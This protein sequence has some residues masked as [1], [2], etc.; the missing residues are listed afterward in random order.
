MVKTSADGRIRNAWFQITQP[1][2]ASYVAGGF[3][4]T[5]P[6]VSLIKNASVFMTPETLLATTKNVGLVL[7][8]TGAVATVKVLQRSDAA[9]WTEVIDGIN[10]SGANF[11][12]T[13][14]GV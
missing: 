12:L 13:G 3:K 9:L 8:T 5:V 14:K 6:G 1:G 7:T 11:I 10:L 4:I 2:T